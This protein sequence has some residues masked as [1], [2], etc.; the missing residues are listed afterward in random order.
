MINVLNILS[1]ERKI[2]QK[3]IE[4]INNFAQNDCRKCELRAGCFLAAAD[5]K[6]ARKDYPCFYPVEGLTKE[7]IKEELPLEVRQV[8]KK[9][10]IPLYIEGVIITVLTVFLLFAK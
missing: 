1:A 7:I 10:L 6:Q 4:K 3:E 9:L 8:I 2:M 5:W